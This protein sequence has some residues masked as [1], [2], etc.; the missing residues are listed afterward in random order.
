MPCS[1]ELS[2]KIFIT[3]RPDLILLPDNLVTTVLILLNAPKAGGG[4][5]G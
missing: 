5:G 3:L 2:M 4:G 1:A